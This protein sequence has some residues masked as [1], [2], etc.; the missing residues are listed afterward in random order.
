MVPNNTKQVPSHHD[1][2]ATAE[3]VDPLDPEEIAR[4]HYYTTHIDTFEQIMAIN[5]RKTKNKLKF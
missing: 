1:L 2:I 4:K 5:Q 3:G